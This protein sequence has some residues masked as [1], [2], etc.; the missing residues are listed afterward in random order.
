MVKVDASN[1][2]I[3]L[4]NPK[5]MNLVMTGAFVGYTGIL[6]EENVL[7]TAFRKLGAKRPELN[8]LNEAA[9]RRGL[10]IGKAARGQE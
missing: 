7:A 9:F 2:A 5:V 8:P 1:I 3:E 6:P 10:A 4:G